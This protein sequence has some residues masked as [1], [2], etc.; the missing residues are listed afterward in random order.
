MKM[1]LAPMS[2]R[3]RRRVLRWLGGAL[4][5]LVIALVGVAAVAGF[6]DRD[7]MRFIG[8]FGRG[9]TPLAAVF[10]SGDM[11]LNFGM[12]R[13]V[14]RA[15]AAHDLPVLG[16][17][18]PTIF[19]QHR[20][21]AEVDAVVA[22]AVRAALAHAHADR[23]VLIGQSFGS[24][25]LSTGVAALPADLRA[26]VAA[27]VLVVPGRTVFFRADPTELAYRGAPDGHAID[28]MR[29]V[30]WT[31]V[32]CIYGQREIDSLC[33]LLTDPGVRRIVLPG[34]HFLNNDP[35][36]LIATIVAALRPILPD[37]TPA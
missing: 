17:N 16:V 24:D 2:R 36:R 5:L 3:P 22:D 15:L 8:D 14:T 18:S 7:P 1:R 6:F 23:V 25:M 26:K 33:P 9:R 31:P 19:R 20:T 13:P 28:T 34:G 32:T 29:T 37:E 35:D 27:V 10:F 12:G 21:R 4:A 30:S 11:G